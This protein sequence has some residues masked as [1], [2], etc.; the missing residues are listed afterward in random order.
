MTLPVTIHIDRLP[1]DKFNIVHLL[2]EFQNA[3]H[4]LTD[5]TNHG[6]AVLVQRKFH[7]VQTGVESE[8]LN[9]LPYTQEV[10]R[11]IMS[12]HKFDSA[13][14]RMVMPNTCYNW[15]VDK[16]KVCVHVPIITNPGCKFI[17]EHKAFSMPAD[18]SAYV[19]NNGIAHTFMNAGPEPRLHLTFENLD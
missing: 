8:E 2:N 19:V 17:Y 4:L 9:N 5:V 7:L 11:T 15:H 3:E 18:G 6:N 12:I 13:N 14:Y 10:I 16:G 1:I